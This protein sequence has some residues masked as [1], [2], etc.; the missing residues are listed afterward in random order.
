VRTRDAEST[1]KPPAG[2]KATPRRD[3]FCHRTRPPRKAY[4][5]AWKLF[6]PKSLPRRLFALN[7]LSS[8]LTS[9]LLGLRPDP[10]PQTAHPA[11][12]RHRGPTNQEPWW[13]A[14][15]SLAILR[16][17]ILKT[18]FSNTLF[19]DR[20]QEKTSVNHHIY[21]YIGTIYP[22]KYSLRLA[23]LPQVGLYTRYRFKNV[24]EKATLV[25]FALVGRVPSF[26]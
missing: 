21:I 16:A 25:V 22:K 6:S 1:A 17:E 18:P 2:N 26:L 13:A 9:S 7:A 23:L 3:C 8:V 19:D 10:T 12:R 24:G 11:R 20:T 4:P 14:G 5:V 15:I